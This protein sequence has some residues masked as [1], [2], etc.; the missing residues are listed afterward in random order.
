[1][2]LS[3][4]RKGAMCGKIWGNKIVAEPNKKAQTLRGLL[5]GGIDIFCLVERFLF[6]VN[7][8]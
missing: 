5:I 8:T 3:V 4:V 7:L 2:G 6:G 1:M